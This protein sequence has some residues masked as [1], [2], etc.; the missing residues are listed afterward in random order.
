MRGK[1]NYNGHRAVLQRLAVAASG[2]LCALAPAAVITLDFNDQTVGTVIDTEYQTSHGI[3]F[4][5]DDPANH[6]LTLYD[7]ES[8][9]GPDEDLEGPPDDDW[10]DGNLAPSTKLGNLLIINDDS[11]PNGVVDTP[12]DYAGGG[13]ITIEFDH[14]LFGLGLAGVDIE[15][16]EAEDHRIDFYRNSTLLARV[17]FSD[18]SDSDNTDFYDG[19]VKYGDDTA[20]RLPMIWYTD[21]NQNVVNGSVDIGQGSGTI[22]IFDEV[23]IRLCGSGGIAAVRY[24]PTPEPGTLLL[25]GLGLACL[26][27]AHRRRR[28]STAP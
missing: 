15:T 25:F 28:R 9:G 20:N 6:P 11:A 14:E 19:S 3:T 1:H 5:A 8:T 22:G 13:T 23:R 24:Q 12:D 27:P 26:L 2:I 18:F 16:S 21:P 7:S 10:N 4:S 17:F